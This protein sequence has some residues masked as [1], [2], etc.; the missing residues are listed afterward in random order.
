MAKSISN[1]KLKIFRKFL[2]S[3]GCELIRTRGGHEVWSHPNTPR[4][5][6]IQ[7]HIDPIPTFIVLNN[8][9]TLGITKEEFLKAIESL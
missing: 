9:K 7:S 6:I 3:V 8:L 1:I 5:I 4:P 2:Q